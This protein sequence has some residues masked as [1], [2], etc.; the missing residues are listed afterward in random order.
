MAVAVADKAAGPAFVDS[1]AA[2]AAVAVAVVAAVAVTV[3]DCSPH[4]LLPSVRFSSP[5]APQ[6]TV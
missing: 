6:G 3:A 4:Y 2:A 1:F 5:S